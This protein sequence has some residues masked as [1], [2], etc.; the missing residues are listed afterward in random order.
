MMIDY[1]KVGPDIGGSDL[2]RVI[3]LSDT[4]YYMQTYASQ[5]LNGDASFSIFYLDITNN[6]N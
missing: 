2:N 5:I 3:F 6:M 1:I 4:R